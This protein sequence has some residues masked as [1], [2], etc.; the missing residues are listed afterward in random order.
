[1]V[2]IESTKIGNV[3]KRRW[4]ERDEGKSY[5]SAYFICSC[6]CGI[7]NRLTRAA[8]NNVLPASS[9][10]GSQSRVKVRVRVRCMQAYTSEQKCLRP[11]KD[12]KR[13][14]PKLWL[15]FELLP[16]LGGKAAKSLCTG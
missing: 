9:S 13:Q 2:R 6:T 5:Q 12:Y 4:S 16:S 15:W 11:H 7:T 3:G 1:M 8:N 10:M 14:I